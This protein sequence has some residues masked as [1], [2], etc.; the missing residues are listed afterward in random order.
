MCD[1]CAEREW[2]FLVLIRKSVILLC[3]EVIKNFFLKD[4]WPKGKAVSYKMPV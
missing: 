4:F 3:D 1:P 2:E